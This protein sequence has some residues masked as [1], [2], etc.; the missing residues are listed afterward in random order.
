[1]T[2]EQLVRRPV[3]ER[4]AFEHLVILIDRESIQKFGI[5]QKL[6]L[7]RHV[8]TPSKV[9]IYPNAKKLVIIVS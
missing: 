7:N 2:I 9:I 8:R 4:T 5:L 3:L 1:V 6:A